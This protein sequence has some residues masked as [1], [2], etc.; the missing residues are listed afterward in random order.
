M[1]ET[2]NYFPFSTIHYTKK[3]GQ[4][5]YVCLELTNLGPVQDSLVTKYL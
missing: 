5:V 3:K 2:F 1:I 4:P